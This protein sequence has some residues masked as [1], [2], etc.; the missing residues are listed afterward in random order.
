M[1]SE[2]FG[3]CICQVED[4]LQVVSEHALDARFLTLQ[5]IRLYKGE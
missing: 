4:A 2:V 3:I 5:N 1:K